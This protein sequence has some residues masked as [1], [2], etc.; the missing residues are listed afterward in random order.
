[1]TTKTV[2][3]NVPSGGIYVYVRK[4]QQGKSELI[5]LNGTNDEQ[6]F[7]IHQYKDILDGFRYGQELVSG[8]KI[9]LTKNM[10]LNA[11][12]SLIIEL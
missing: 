4:H 5:I 6:N 12:Q 1:M 11:R 3:H 10:Q 7:P 2:R 9:D 8:K